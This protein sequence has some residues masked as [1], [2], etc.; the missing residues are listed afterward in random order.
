MIMLRSV[1]SL[2]A[3]PALNDWPS[4]IE[5]GAKNPDSS[6]GR[7]PKL[8][9]AG[10]GTVPPNSSESAVTVRSAINRAHGRPPDEAPV[11][12]AVCVDVPSCGRGKGEDVIRE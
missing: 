1:E 5:I 10:I 2:Y 6:P 7:S 3:L 9:G 11:A 12:I 4:V 8:A